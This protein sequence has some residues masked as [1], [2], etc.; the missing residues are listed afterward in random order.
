MS[1]ENPAVKEIVT[2]IYAT[3][4]GHYPGRGPTPAGGEAW[5]NVAFAIDEREVKLVPLSFTLAS[6]YGW[7]EPPTGTEDLERISSE[8][9]TSGCD[10]TVRRQEA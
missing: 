10:L 9:K 3:R 1:K 5:E 6:A 4:A 7:V 8:A 2:T